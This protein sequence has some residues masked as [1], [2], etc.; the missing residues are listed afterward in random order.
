[1][2]WLNQGLNFA[3]NRA[4]FVGLPVEDIG[5]TLEKLQQRSDINKAK[6]SQLED[7]LTNLP[8]RE[9]NRSHVENATE[10]LESVMSDIILGGRYEHADMY[11][12]ESVRNLKSDKNLKGAILDYNLYSQHTDMLDKGVEDER[13][14][15]ADRDMALIKSNS[16]S[17]N[18]TV[19]N[20]EL[21]KYE[22]LY[23]GVTP[24]EYVDMNKLIEDKLKVM[25][26]DSGIM[27]QDEYGNWHIVNSPSFL[28]DAGHGYL[29]SFSGETLSEDKIKQ[30]MME[31]FLLDPKVKAYAQWQS[32]NKLLSSFGVRNERGLYE[33]NSDGSFQYEGF[34][35]SRLPELGYRVSENGEKVLRVRTEID[36]NGKEVPILNKNGEYIWEEDDI[37][38]AHLKMAIEDGSIYDRLGEAY[39]MNYVSDYAQYAADLGKYT[40]VDVD[41]MQDWIK[42][43]DLEEASAKRV[44]E[45]QHTL[46]D[47][48]IAWSKT[49]TAQAADFNYDEFKKQEKDLVN[50][51][52][53]TKD[54]A[55]RKELEG[56]LRH[57]RMYE[58]QIIQSLFDN[59]GD[60]DFSKI[61]KDIGEYINAYNK[62]K[63]NDQYKDL[64]S[65][66]P[67]YDKI[68]AMDKAEFSIFYNNLSTG[69]EKLASEYKR[70]TLFG[71]RTALDF[72]DGGS[73]LIS[74]LIANDAILNSITTGKEYKKD[75][76][77]NYMDIYSGDY[78]FNTSRKTKV[79]ET[80]ID[81]NPSFN[82]NIQ[83][84]FTTLY[85][86]KDGKLDP[87]YIALQS[88]IGD[89]LDGFN[90][91]G[92]GKTVPLGEYLND[93]G[94][95]IFAKPGQ[96][97]TDSDG[98]AILTSPGIGSGSMEGFYTITV[99][100]EDG[101]PEELTLSPTAE[102]ANV[103]MSQSGE[104]FKRVALNNAGYY[105]PPSESLPN[106]LEYIQDKIQ[107]TEDYDL[108]VKGMMLD[109]N[110]KYG[111]RKTFD[112]A[113]AIYS[114]TPNNKVE[115]VQYPVN[116]ISRYSGRGV[117]LVIQPVINKEYNDRFYTVGVVNNSS[118]TF[119]LDGE[120]FE[121]GSILP[122]FTTQYKTLEE[123]Q[124]E[125]PN[126]DLE[127]N[128]LF[129]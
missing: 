70:K 51:L 56:Q 30:A 42:K 122:Y 71:F 11:I 2:S 25:K 73:H 79:I 66:I 110:S 18:K 127:L 107:R 22:N 120:V 4:D 13:F 67:D 65:A 50:E 60:S 124:Y 41:Y 52:A 14:T 58:A 78:N 21:Q 19:W 92:K 129:E 116:F 5:I 106:S 75:V 103:A 119:D 93:M 91:V 68:Q 45:Y 72:S 74:P 126:I 82:F 44:A 109:V 15:Q 125:I 40:K 111:T 24:A 77:Y 86:K 89:N 53:N 23:T 9:E 12:D 47:F 83:G 80:F 81:E 112:Q 94:I 57:G 1:M 84:Q 104:L 88:F 64:S 33:V 108:Y 29:A 46:E 35:I 85:N 95:E 96:G 100:N 7:Y 117:E 10:D 59:I 115:N 62:F 102:T 38:T 3:T 118:K 113:A 27:Q 101:V 87:N 97:I 69:L 37:T 26:A 99:L 76:P 16:K 20:E 43:L 39:Q 32:E 114:V 8:V 54:P 61:K 128:K 121:P 105:V 36:V 34:D 63:G 48:K 17:Q 28:T 6:H 123:V 31:G 98:N 49:S 90:V 55:K